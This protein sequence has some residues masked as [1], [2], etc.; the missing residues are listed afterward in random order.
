MNL[1]LLHCFLLWL[2]WPKLGKRHSIT[3][4]YMHMLPLLKLNA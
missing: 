1:Q 4:L 2:E 3:L